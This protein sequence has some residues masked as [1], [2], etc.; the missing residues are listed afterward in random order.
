MKKGFLKA[1]REEKG[2]T[3][4]QLAERAMISRAAYANIESG[5]ALPGVAAAKA[6]ALVLGFDWTDFFSEIQ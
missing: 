6:I 3:Q 1:I 4:K 2:L 5:N